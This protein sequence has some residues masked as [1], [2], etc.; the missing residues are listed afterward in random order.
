MA[1]SANSI[2]VEEGWLSTRLLWP[3]P[4]L[5]AVAMEPWWKWRKRDLDL[6]DDLVGQRIGAIGG[7]DS[8]VQGLAILAKG[9]TGVTILPI[10]GDKIADAMP[11]EALEGRFLDKSL[12]FHPVRA[13]ATITTAPADRPGP[14]RVAVLVG[15]EGPSKAFDRDRELAALKQ[16]FAASAQVSARVVDAGNIATLDLASVQSEAARRAF[17]ADADPHVV[18]YFGHGMAGSAPAIRVGPGKRGWLPLEQLAAWAAND[19]PFPVSWLF[20]A[21]SI[22]EAPSREAGPAGP[23]AFRILAQHGARAMLAMRARIRPRIA[24]IVATSVIESLSAGTPLE[25]AAAPARKTARRAQENDDI[26][27]FDWA[28]PAVWSTV[29]G[30]M[31]VRGSEIPADLVAL[32]THPRG[33]RLIPGS[34]SERRT[35]WVPPLPRGGQAIGVSV[36]T[37]PTKT[38]H[39]WSRALA[40]SPERSAPRR[41][42]PRYLLSPADRLDSRPGWPIGRAW[43]C[44]R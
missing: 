41:G 36:S 29:V 44:R 7:V 30:P 14:L 6:F 42:G 23:D 28:A 16:A 2:Q 43:F 13:D 21:C 22:G 39:R 1:R 17:F 9:S 8:I 10:V 38:A 25:L 40:I 12:Q 18:V 3:D 20:I 4:N 27:L 26:K 11:W 31:P 19:H 5:A 33:C 37:C 34:A 35:P 24:R 15:H 32:Q